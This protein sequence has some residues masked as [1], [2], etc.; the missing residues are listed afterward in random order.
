V[1]RTIR[2]HQTGGPEVFQIED[3]DVP[4]PK[5]GEV[6]ITVKALGLNRAESMFRNGQYLE[7]PQFPARNGYEAAGTVESVGEGVEGFQ[8]GDA[9]STIPGFSLNQYGVYGEV[10]LAPAAMVVKHPASLSWEEAASVWMQYVTA[11]GALIELGKMKKRDTVLIPAASS[12]VGLAAIQIT[13]L[14]G[15]T[16][17]A[18]TRT[19]EKRKALLDAGAKHVIAT[20]EEDLV[21]RVQKLTRGKGARLVFDPVAGPTLAKLAAA[22]KQNGII[23]E[24]GALST[25]PTPF[26][27]FEVLGKLLTVRG[28]V[29]SAVTGDAKRLA[30]AKQFI[31]DGLASGKLKPIISKVF[32]GLDQMVEAHRYMEGNTQIGKIVLTI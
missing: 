29:L 8:P 1:A 23:F 27:L 30:R 12:S 6:R 22:T 9:V 19:N 17:I 26:P 21:E 10:V 4:A 14:I 5:Q 20:E 18:L 31:I 11:Y 13:N 32:K 25:E 7:Q 28:Y 2:F 3:L 16:P 15:A 24:Y